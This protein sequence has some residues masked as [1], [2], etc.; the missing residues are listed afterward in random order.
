MT[1]GRH[2]LSD[3]PRIR[4]A[5]PAKPDFVPEA[6]VPDWWFASVADTRPFEFCSD[7]ALATV[8]TPEPEPG[9]RLV[10]P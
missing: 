1:R 2:R 5:H 9:L 7:E 10:R 6:V 8:Y 4:P 3:A